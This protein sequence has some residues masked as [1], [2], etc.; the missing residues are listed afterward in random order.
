MIPIKVQR[1]S[2]DIRAFSARNV[3]S[4][5][6]LPPKAGLPPFKYF[7]ISACCHGPKKMHVELCDI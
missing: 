4:K 2:G 3:T 1:A 5:L 6:L 7:W